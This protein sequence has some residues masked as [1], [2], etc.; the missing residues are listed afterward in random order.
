MAKAKPSAQAA[1]VHL[2]GEIRRSVLPGGLRVVSEHMPNS[3]TFCLGFFVNVGS[4]HESPALHGASHFLE[5]V[6]FKGT[7]KRSAEQISAAIES[8]GGDINAY[9]AK[10]H[11]CF[12]VRVLDVD[13]DQAID[14]LTDMLSSSLV[15]GAEVEF[16]R[17]VILDEIAMHADD[18]AETAQELVTGRLFGDRDLGRPIIGSVESIEALT[19]QQIVSYW[20][21]HYRP[22][23]IVVS[24]AGNVDHD[25][26]VA[27]LAEFDRQSDSGRARREALA[28]VVPGAAVLTKTKPTEQSTA[29]LAFG[30]PGVF[31]PRRYPLGLLSLIVGG[32]MSSRLFVDIRERRG[33]AYG[34]DAGETSYSDAGLWSVDWQSAPSRMAEILTLVRQC[35]VDVAEHGVTDEEIARAKGQMRGQ[36]VL[37]YE[38]PSSRMSRLGGSE[39]IGDDRSLAEV[40]ALYDAVTAED[41]QQEAITL[42][43]QQPV[44]GLVGPKLAKRELT[45]I[46][47]G[48]S[49]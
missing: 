31:D 26:L 38:G 30:G 48:W 27:R 46:I 47:N 5:H 15:L 21:R 33:L 36:T 24:A 20:R 4:R 17:Q 41:I 1:R 6:L 25:Q 28:K 3:R 40:L 32:G 34:I 35:L 42:F 39:L 19:R 16:E 44:L 10:E 14:V 9:T 45:K 22:S 11:T 13:A 29:V 49:H 37:S 43:G 12:Y 7:A 23:Q 2:G 8:V 18:P